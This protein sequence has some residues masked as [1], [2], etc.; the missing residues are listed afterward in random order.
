MV[1]GRCIKTLNAHIDYVTA[2]HFNRDGSLVVSCSLDGLMYVIYHISSL[3]HALYV[4]AQS[5]LEFTI[6]TMPQDPSRGAEC[7]LVRESPLVPP[8]AFTTHA[9]TLANTCSSPQIRNTFSPLPTTAPS[10]YGTSRRR[11]VSKRTS[12]TKTQSTASP[13]ASVSRAASGLCRG[14][15]TARFICGTCK[16]ERSCRYLMVIVASAFLFPRRLL[17]ADRLHPCRRCC[18]CRGKRS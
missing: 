18:S 3:A 2:V 8:V 10:A 7:H 9:S 16:A 6:R 1:S 13:R 17:F 4:P 15:K 12:A 11:A 14:A 5:H